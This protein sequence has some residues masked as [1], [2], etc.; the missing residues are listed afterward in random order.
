ML[1]GLLENA[2]HR[3]NSYKDLSKKT[4]NNP[5]KRG[6]VGKFTDKRVSQSLRFMA[7]GEKNAIIKKIFS[8]EKK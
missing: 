5:A 6:S 4:S 7:S 8:T 2:F 3:F 1:I